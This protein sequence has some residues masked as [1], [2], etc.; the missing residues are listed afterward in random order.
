MGYDYDLDDKVM[1]KNEDF[2]PSWDSYYPTYDKMQ[3]KKERLERER[4]DLIKYL[5]LL[6]QDAEPDFT[7]EYVQNMTNEEIKKEIER[8]KDA[9]GPNMSG[10]MHV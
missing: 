8:E 7:R 2:I 9:Q 10:G 1:D 4:E 6:R 5:N 3:E